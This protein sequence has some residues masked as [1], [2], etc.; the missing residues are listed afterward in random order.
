MGR[1]LVLGCGNALGV[2]PV[3]SDPREDLQ[4]YGDA[5]DK[6]LAE[7]FGVPAGQSPPSI[8][9]QLQARS[10]VQGDPPLCEQPHQI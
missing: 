5:I 1:A 10:P 4:G 9:Q 7:A 2:L 3:M 8:L 6:G